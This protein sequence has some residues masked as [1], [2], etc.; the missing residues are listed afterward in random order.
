LPFFLGLAP[1]LLLA[2][3]SPIEPVG[4]TGTRGRV[5]N[6][7]RFSFS[8]APESAGYQ[9]T[10]WLL[11]S[12]PR[13]RSLFGATRAVR[14]EPMDHLWDGC[15]GEAAR[16]VDAGILGPPGAGYPDTTLSRTIEEIRDGQALGDFAL[17]A[18]CSQSVANSDV[19]S[20]NSASFRSAC[21]LSLPSAAH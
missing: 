14:A 16:N 15:I 17:A 18:V 3:E 4:Y 21:H 9:Q 8:K 7:F 20:A 5:S 11:G 2:T 10:A 19:G 1:P 13:V 12:P 6:P